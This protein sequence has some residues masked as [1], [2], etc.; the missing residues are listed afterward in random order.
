M[1]TWTLTWQHGN[2]IGLKE[3]LAA[4]RSIV[5]KIILRPGDP[6][7]LERDAYQRTSFLLLTD[8][9]RAL[10]DVVAGMVRMSNGAFVTVSDEG[11]RARGTRRRTPRGKG[12]AE[13]R[14]G[15]ERKR[16]R[17][18]GREKLLLQWAVK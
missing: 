9:G 18:G 13:G 3:Y 5:K 15:R 14:K 12:G 17:G 11:E 6:K 7:S 8:K 10:D 4:L 1:L 16:A 2:K